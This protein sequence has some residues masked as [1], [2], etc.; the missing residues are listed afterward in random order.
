[1]IRRATPDDMEHVVELGRAF[2]AY[3]PWR[4]VSYDHDAIRAFVAGCIETGAIFLSET[5]MCGGLVSPL[6]FNPAFRIG[7]EFF[8]WA[9]DG[10]SAL[11]QAFEDWAREEGAQGVQ[12]SALSDEHLPAVTRI[13]RRSGFAPAETAFVKRFT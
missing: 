7:V 11:R 4:G 13:Y 10:G 6:Y 8:W 1:M 2:H 3:S 5:G 9:P 12:F